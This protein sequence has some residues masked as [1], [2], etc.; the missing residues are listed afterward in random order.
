M[1]IITDAE[2]TDARA[3]AEETFLS[4]CT[5]NKVTITST[6]GS[7]AKSY[8]ERAAGVSCRIMP[9]SAGR[10]P[11]YMVGAAEVTQK[12]NYVLTIPWDQVIEPSDQ[13]VTGGETYE[14]LGVRDNHDF[15]TAVRADL[16]LVV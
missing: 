9:I 12:A 8:S 1:T 14:V 10:Q 13:V 2:L 4:T 15:R 11:E 16:V 5:I 7:V 6:K 3:Q